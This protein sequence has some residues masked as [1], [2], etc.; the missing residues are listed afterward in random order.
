MR[1]KFAYLTMKNNSFARAFSFFGHVADVLVPSA[2]WK[3]IFWSC[4]DDR[5]I[6]WQTVNF[7]AL[8]LKRW[9]QFNFR[10]AWTN[11]ASITTLNN[12]ERIA[13]TRSYIFRCSRR[14]SSSLLTPSKPQMTKFFS[15]F[16]IHSSQQILYSWCSFRFATSSKK[17]LSKQCELV[18]GVTS[19]AVRPSSL[20]KIPFVSWS[21]SFAFMLA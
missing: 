11:F 18:F 13:Q 20:R 3:N 16:L 2:T 15:K 10:I 5:S 7:V 9:F 14:C 17:S 6:W 8:F 19:S 12:W 1:H 4:K 21:S